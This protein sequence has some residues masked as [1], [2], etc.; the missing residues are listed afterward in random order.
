MNTY[1]MRVCAWY[2]STSEGSLAKWAKLGKTTA[3][4]EGDQQRLCYDFDVE[5]DTVQD[6][7]AEAASTF[8]VH[9]LDCGIVDPTSMNITLF[10]S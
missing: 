9:C 1:S 4:P 10:N 5:A 8:G 3:D 7:F 6:A 2:S